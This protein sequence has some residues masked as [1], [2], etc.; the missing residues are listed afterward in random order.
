M[1]RLAFALLVCSIATLHAQEQ[2]YDLIVANGMV[3]DGTGGEA[4]RADVGV[5]AG[6]IA[7]IGDLSKAQSKRT[8]DARGLTVAPGSS[9]CITTRTICCCRSPSVKA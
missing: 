5:R 3:I 8:I 2:Q 7:A 6:K 1:T 9:T 4:R